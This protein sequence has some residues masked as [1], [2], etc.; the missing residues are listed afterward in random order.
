MSG[1]GKFAVFNKRHRTQPQS[2][3]PDAG[4]F[5][6]FTHHVRKGVG[7]LAGNF[8][9]LSLHRL[10]EVSGGSSQKSPIAEYFRRIFGNLTQENIPAQYLANLLR[11]ILAR[12]AQSD[13]ASGVELEVPSGSADKLSFGEFFKEFGTI[14]AKFGVGLEQTFASVAQL[15][16][17]ITD[18]GLAEFMRQAFGVP[19]PDAPGA[20]PVAA[21]LAVKEILARE[22]Q[23]TVA[24]SSEL[25]IRLLEQTVKVMM[26]MIADRI[27]K[28]EIR[29]AELDAH[30]LAAAG[31]YDQAPLSAA[32]EPTVKW[33]EA[34]L[35]HARTTCTS[36]LAALRRTLQDLHE[37]GTGWLMS[38]KGAVA[39]PSKR[40]ITLSPLQ[41]SA[42]L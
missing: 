5:F 29:L 27:N 6:I 19:Q 3:T 11:T 37:V 4:V 38:V 32:L 18:V 30:E 22:T 8:E 9:V 42:A 7:M 28:L 1:R 26:I 17:N 24:I 41:G 21:G 34:V 35:D 13:L 25:A 20:V 15:A 10:R 2:K 23:R 16:S 31:E 33:G 39:T 40:P 14:F 12:L 36:Q